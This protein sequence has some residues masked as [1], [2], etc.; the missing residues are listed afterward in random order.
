VI[1]HFN[2]Q[3]AKGNI[4]FYSSP[5]DVDLLGDGANKGC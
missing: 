5:E 2:E 4:N 3:K 1:P